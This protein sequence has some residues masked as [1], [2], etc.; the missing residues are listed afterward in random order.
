MSN[1][2]IAILVFAALAVGAVIGYLALKFQHEKRSKHLRQHFGPEYSRLAEERGVTSAERE[3]EARE[4]RTRAYHIHPLTVEQ[5]MQLT[6]NW[7]QVQAEFVD[8][9]KD[10]LGQ[11]DALLQQAMEARGYPVNTFEQCAADL[12]VQHPAVV[13][14][15]REAHAIALR[16]REGKTSTED[17]RQAMLHYRALFEELVEDTSN[18]DSNIPHDRKAAHT[19]DS[20]HRSVH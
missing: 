10:S 6:A 1:M 12:S 15:Y 17:L 20:H 16:H 8:N 14:H 9:P 7:K 5:K 18:A 4:K 2:E 13:Q 19:T 11:A 3:L